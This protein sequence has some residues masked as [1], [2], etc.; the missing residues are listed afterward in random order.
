[1]SRT[2]SINW[3][4]GDSLNASVRW[5]LTPKARQLRLIAVSLIDTDTAAETMTANK[6]G[7]K[8]GA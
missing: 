3:G 8:L 7:R 2:L 1:M 4:L 6:P 5:G